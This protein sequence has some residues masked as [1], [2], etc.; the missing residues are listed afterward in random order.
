MD[1]IVVKNIEI[2]ITGIQDD[3]YISLTDI[4]RLKSDDDTNSVISNWLRRVD[5][6][7]FL[8]L[9]ETSNN[10]DFKGVEFEGFKSKPGENAFSIS[11]K[12]GLK[13]L[14]PL[15]LE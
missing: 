13:Y 9:W 11:A 1:K 12:N 5:T 4:A 15:E 14:E 8:K 10:P 3:D 2:N 7:E 6:L